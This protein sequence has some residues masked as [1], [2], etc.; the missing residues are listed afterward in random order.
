MSPEHVLTL[1]KRAATQKDDVASLIRRA[2]GI[3]LDQPPI[4]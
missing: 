1:R 3:N 4:P 2:I